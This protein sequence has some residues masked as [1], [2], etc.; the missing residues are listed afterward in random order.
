MGGTNSIREASWDRGRRSGHEDITG[1]TSIFSELIT[2]RARGVLEA[3]LQTRDRV[4]W[5]RSIKSMTEHTAHEYGGRFLLELLQN[6]YDAHPREFQDGRIC[7]R[8]D[9]T[10]ENHGVLYVANAGRG[11][12]ESNFRAICNLGLS[13]KPVGEGIG[14]KGV[15]FKSVLQICEAPEI[16][17]SDPDDVKQPGF[18][19]RFARP[20]DIPGL[21]DGDDAQTEQILTDVS[22]YTVPVPLEVSDSYVAEL[23]EQ[24]FATVL[25]MPLR[26]SIAL[27]ETRKRLEELSGSNVPVLLFLRRID[28][29]TIEHVCRE[30]LNRRDLRRAAIDLRCEGAEAQRVR[31]TEGDEF[32]VFSR[33]VNPDELHIAITKAVEAELLD[34]RWL[35]WEAPAS[36]SV[37]V[38]A[39]HEITEFR[40][41]TYLP[42]GSKA[43]APFAG[44]LNAPFFTNLARVD[45]DLSHPL[46][47]MLLGACAEL[48]L[49][50]AQTLASGVESGWEKAVVDLISWKADVVDHLAVIKDPDGVQV[51]DQKLLPTGQPSNPLTSM[52]EGWRWPLPEADI[53]T[54]DLAYRAAGMSPICEE[55]G[56]A[57][58]DRLRETMSALGFELYPLPETLAVWVE[59]MAAHCLHEDLSLSGWDL[60]YNEIASMF[61]NHAEVLTGRRLL[62]SDEHELMPC[63]GPR[64]SKEPR[65]QS[66]PFFPPVRQRIEDEDVVEADADLALPSDV[67]RRI[68]LPA[69]R[70]HLVRREPG[71]NPR[72]CVLS[73]SPSR[74][75]VRCPQ[76]V[77]APPV[78]P[79][80]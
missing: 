2:E 50:A 73:G 52:A 55:L 14:N 44:H 58:L 69:L 17:S 49:T 40:S 43:P 78:N 9:E 46:N 8:L 54:A 6:A 10:A 34:P 48:A 4:D 63:S 70:S 24:G 26:S 13:D 35:K 30:G 39:S 11:F 60:L 64:S 59:K 68:F 19:F 67:K 32:F 53:L 27:E 65:R 28:L 3:Y 79:D 22:L 23:R 61:E 57:R 18:S 75:P 66:T 15:G 74:P 25:R 56:E 80:Q 72:P 45:V 62:L 37:A 16:Y 41:Y 38:A 36:I 21:V 5:G 71:T 47:S 77:G 7:I 51:G 1:T 42:M 76:P 12:T 33:D 31:L 20:E 29:L